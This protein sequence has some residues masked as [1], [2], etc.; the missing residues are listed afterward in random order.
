MEEPERSSEDARPGVEAGDAAEALRRIL[1]VLT[2]TLPR[3]TEESR[4]VLRSKTLHGDFVV[5]VRKSWELLLK[6]LLISWGFNTDIENGATH[7][8][9][10]LVG[11]LPHQKRVQGAP[12]FDDAQFKEFCHL[13]TSAKESL[14]PYAHGRTDTDSRLTHEHVRKIYGDLRIAVQLAFAGSQRALSL[15]DLQP[16]GQRMAWVA[17]TALVLTLPALLYARQGRS[18][19]ATTPATRSVAIV[20]VPFGARV[21]ECERLGSAY[22]S[23]QFQGGSRQLLIEVAER[24]QCLLFRAADSSACCPR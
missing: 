12:L 16:L 15:P 19:S 18:A 4:R 14:N 8:L 5:P 21:S 23:L 13:A 3:V 6:Y 1:L 2:E 17:A 10:S 9:G 20:A 7:T 11:R 24:R 22:Q